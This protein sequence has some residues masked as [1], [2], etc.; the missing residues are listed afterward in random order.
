MPPAGHDAG[1]AIGAALYQYCVNLGNKPAEVQMHS[2]FGSR[3][4]NVEI[5]KVLQAK[6]VSYK[7]LDEKALFDKVTDCLINGGVVGWF[8]AGRP[9]FGPRAL[10]H[11]SIIA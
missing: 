2:Y 1:T 11:R 10:G 4:T 8:R 5:E 7:Q 6:N 3:A 9:E